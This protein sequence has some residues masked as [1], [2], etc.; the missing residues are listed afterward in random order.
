VGLGE[1]SIDDGGNDLP[2]F[3]AARRG[4]RA[5][6][7]AA[8]R[9]IAALVEWPMRFYPVW[10]Y[11]ALDRQCLSAPPEEAILLL[12]GLLGGS[13]GGWA[14]STGIVGNWPL[15]RPLIAPVTPEA[16][17][18]ESVTPVTKIAHGLSPGRARLGGDILH[19][20]AEES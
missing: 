6:A 14:Y 5:L 17:G 16:A 19:F 1:P 12:R 9:A 20:L 7:M 11:G 15:E 18:F 8:G 3:L 13:K 10:S 4:R 2:R